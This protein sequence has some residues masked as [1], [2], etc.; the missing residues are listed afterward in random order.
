MGILKLIITGQK[1]RR[2]E[3][4]YVSLA[5]FI[6]V[7][8]MSSITLFQTVMDRY[9]METNYQNYGDWVMSAVKDYEDS[10]VLFSELYHPYFAASGVC[11]TGAELLN[12]Q[13]EPG[14]ACLGT[15]DD[16]VRQFGNIS[17]YEGRFPKNEQEIAMDL[18]SLSALGYSY[19]TG[20][21]IRVAVR[22]EDEIT[23]QEFLLTGLLK[24]FAANWKHSFRYPLPNC[25][26]TAEGMERVCAPRYATYFYQL[27]RS[28]E[29]LDMEE[30]T[31]A[32]FFSGHIREYNSYVYENR[33]WGSKEM[34]RSVKLL[35]TLIGALAVGYL[36]LSYVSQRR[37]WYYKLRCA[38]ADKGQLRLIILTE[39]VCG[40]FLYALLGMAVPYAIGAAVCGGLSIGLKL[41]YF[42]TFH[43]TDF[44]GQMGTAFGIILFVVLCAWFGCRDKNLS[45]NSNTVTKQQLR[46]LR[47]DAKKERNVG[48]IFLRRQRKLHP[49]Q[50][51]AFVLFSFGVC[52]LL[53]LCVNRLYQSV[54]EYRLAKENM[55]DFTAR[56][57]NN[58]EMITPFYNQDGFGGGGGPMYDMY[59]GISDAGEAEIKSLIGIQD[60][61]RKTM[62]QTHILQW[63]DKK[64][65]P[66]ERRIWQDYQ[67]GSL[68]HSDTVFS[69]YES[70]DNIL[71]ELDRDFELDGL[72]RE[73][74]RNGEE[75]VLLLSP[76]TPYTEM[77]NGTNGQIQE[78]TI[79]AG[80]TVEIVSAETQL[81]VPQEIKDHDS[82]PGCVSVK[83]GAIIKDPPI[84][85]KSQTGYF[86]IYAI[87]A[88]KK[89]AEQVAKADGQTLFYN[90]FEI[91]LNSNSS[92]ESTQK[93][94]A[95]IFKEQEFEYGSDSEAITLL[96]NT[97][98]RN[99]CI[100]GV[101]L[102]TILFIFLLLQVHFH[103]LQDQYRAGE[104][105]LLK[106]LGMEGTFWGRISLKE[107]FLETV[108]MIFSV[109]CSYAVMAAE[110][111]ADLK[112][113][114]ETI[115]L[116][117]WSDTL[118]DYTN[119]LMV[120]TREQ[121]QVYANLL[122][123]AGFVLGLIVAL[124]G[125]RYL[126]IRRA[127]SAK[128]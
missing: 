46:R 11:V 82:L 51:T 10:S 74:F 31:S 109:P 81:Y 119:D 108:W 116:Y 120:L 25:I 69:Y 90:N 127:V 84:K 63:Q 95:A 80:D 128:D 18:S 8:F 22:Q 42:F 125:V 97:Y 13:N 39:A 60:I 6:A 99:L 50:H 93:R 98:I 34:F 77:Q 4:W 126:V 38:G 59:Y 78:T 30:F 23:E 72:N 96:R 53:T 107:S 27:N 64:D 87:L 35:L 37:K 40:T 112:N 101:L 67:N 28:Y 83:V 26:V 44:F 115:G 5:T 111:Y 113:Q 17:L 104:Y 47:R 58:L 73:A 45:R 3:M 24:S 7:L 52:L 55:H 121:M 76:F 49:F 12:E 43:P 117:I 20:Q 14:N 15:V 85:W 91:D 100:Y 71:S 19:E 124:M 75:I 2:R 61:N 9:L 110:F 65:S 21:T 103:Q 62:D 79:H 32:F 68:H 57:Q 88:S 92:F 70:C 114:K 105:R 106:G 16:A 41:P 54:Q 123:T 29:D 94:L 56:K 33:I 86:A 118:N 102:C 48:R 122:V 36:M 1:R 89:L 66:I